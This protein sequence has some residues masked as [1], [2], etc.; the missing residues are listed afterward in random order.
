LSRNEKG[1]Y[2]PGSIHD[3]DK[4][5]RNRAL[6]LTLELRDPKQPD[7]RATPVQYIAALE[8]QYAEMIDLADMLDKAAA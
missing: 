2:V 4:F 5:N 7:V 6:E 3:A 1:N 8:S